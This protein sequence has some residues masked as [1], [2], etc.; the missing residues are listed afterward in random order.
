MIL[1]HKDILLKLDQIEHKLAGH[2]DNILLIFEYLRQ[3]EQSRQQ[4]EQLAE[5]RRIGFRQD[6]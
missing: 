1:L 2:D 6:D 4:E 5:R 3:L